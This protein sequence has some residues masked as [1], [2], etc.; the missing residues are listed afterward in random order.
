MSTE[1]SAHF[2]QVVAETAKLADSLQKTSK[3]RVSLTKTITLWLLVLL[4]AGIVY[5]AIARAVNTQALGSVTESS[6]RP[7]L[8]APCD[9]LTH[10]DID[11]ELPIKQQSFATGFL[12][13]TFEGEL[14][15]GTFGMVEVWARDGKP[16]VLRQFG[17]DSADIQNETIYSANLCCP[18]LHSVGAGESYDEWVI[19]ATIE[20]LKGK[21]R[22]TLPEVILAE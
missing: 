19:G 12:F 17:I 5:V 10:C 21:S 15:P 22:R 9:V 8:L 6:L 16:V 7:V 13:V 11:P 3:G 20:V 18:D 2:D 14:P 4:L 1:G